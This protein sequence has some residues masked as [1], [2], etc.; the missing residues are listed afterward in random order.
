VPAAGGYVIPGLWDMHVHLTDLARNASSMEAGA[1][2]LSR[3]ADLAGHHR[4]PRSQRRPRRDPKGAGQMAGGGSGQPSNPG[5]RLQARHGGGGTGR[6]RSGS[7][8]R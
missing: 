6:A 8:R 1:R 5:W 3:A 4:G 2:L 7:R